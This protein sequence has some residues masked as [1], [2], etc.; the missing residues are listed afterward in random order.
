M[1]P[2]HPGGVTPEE[3]LM[4]A[5]GAAPAMVAAHIRSCQIC[6]AAAGEYVHTATGFRERLYRFDCPSAHDLGEYALGLRAVPERSR[7]AAHIVDCPRCTEELQV[8]RAFLNDEAPVPAPGG[9]ERLRRLV[10]TLL[11]PPVVPVAGLRGAEDGATR[12][13]QALDISLTLATEAAPGGQTAD[14]VG[15]LWRE[16]A[17]AIPTA[18]AT[19]TLIALDEARQQTSVDAFGNFAFVGIKPASYRLEIALGNDRI[20]IEDLIIT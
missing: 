19:V 6:G 13:Y 12:T 10:A 16:Q 1:G 14:L 5:D 3:A 4:Y 17:G 20:V 15:L 2:W 8:L 18:D 7:T 11:P 9:T